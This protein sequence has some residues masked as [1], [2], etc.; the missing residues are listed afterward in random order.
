[1]GN[2][3]EPLA[4]LLPMY[5]IAGILG[6]MSVVITFYVNRESS[7]NTTDGIYKTYI[8]ATSISILLSLIATMK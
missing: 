6:L 2:D 7:I 5:I 1:M 8:I 4:A 3:L